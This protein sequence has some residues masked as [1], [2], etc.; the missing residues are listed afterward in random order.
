MTKQSHKGRTIVKMIVHG[1]LILLLV[2][3]LILPR[4]LNAAES[5]PAPGS[6]TKS[7]AETK[8]LSG[9]VVSID[10]VTKTLV[11]KSWRGE[12]AFDTDGLKTGLKNVKPGDRVRISYIEKNGKKAAKALV[13]TSAGSEGKKTELP[14]IKSL[15]KGSDN[16]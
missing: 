13:V 6:Q 9:T 14:P 1:L 5:K 3:G 12:T 10:S 15:K 4:G 11:I 16:N 8:R 7:R 2:S